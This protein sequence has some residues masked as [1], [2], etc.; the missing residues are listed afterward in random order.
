MHLQN[1][2]FRHKTTNFPQKVKQYESYF[3][4]LEKNKKNFIYFYKFVFQ[5]L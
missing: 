3:I 1:I 4:I 5:K 2:I